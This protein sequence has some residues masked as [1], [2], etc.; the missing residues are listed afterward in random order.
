MVRIKKIC[1]AVS[2]SS[3]DSNLEVEGQESR[4]VMDLGSMI[5]NERQPIEIIL[6]KYFET[7][8][9]VM[10]SHEYQSKWD[11]LIDEILEARMEPANEIDKYAVAVYKDEEIVGHLPKGRTGKFAKMIFY[12][13]KSETLCSCRVKVTGKRINL[14]DNKGMRIPCLLQFSGPNVNIDILEKLLK[15]CN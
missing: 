1:T 11:P 12:F 3:I 6:L 4:R 14:G 10:G 5:I 9:T 13:L 2:F 8:S 7:N 15:D